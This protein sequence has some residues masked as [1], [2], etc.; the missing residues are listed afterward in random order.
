MLFFSA[1]RSSID[2]VKMSR[3][4]SNRKQSVKSRPLSKALKPN[5]YGSTPFHDAAQSGEFEFCEI[6]MNQMIKNNV[7]DKNPKDSY[8]ETPLH[9]AAAN[10]HQEICKLIMDNV[11]NKCPIAKDGK[12]PLHFAAR[13]DHTETI[14]I[15]LKNITKEEASIQFYK[16]HI[17]KEEFSMQPCPKTAFEKHFVSKHGGIEPRGMTPCEYAVYKNERE[18]AEIFQKYLEPKNGTK[19]EIEEDLAIIDQLDSP[20]GKGD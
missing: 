20:I 13:Y 17:C 14:E 5:K 8:G 18:S 1:P 6:V 4:Q 2:F 19:N 15:I 11:E 7:K 10:G 3:K 16:C 9:N 12:I